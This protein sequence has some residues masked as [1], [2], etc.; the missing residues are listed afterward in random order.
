MD[1]RKLTLEVI[2]EMEFAND[3]EFFAM[4]EEEQKQLLKAEQKKEL[5][6]LE[7]LKNLP[8]WESKSHQIL[9]RNHR[10][11][12]RKLKHYEK[13]EDLFVEEEFEA[14]YRELFNFYDS[15]NWHKWR[16]CHKKYKTKF[17]DWLSYEL[18]KKLAWTKI[19]YDDIRGRVMVVVAGMI[20]EVDTVT[21]IPFV[22]RLKHKVFKN[23]YTNMI[24]DIKKPKRLLTYSQK[25]RSIQQLLEVGED[26]SDRKAHLY[27][28]AVLY[29]LDRDEGHR[30][31]LQAMDFSEQENAILTLWKT[32]PDISTRKLSAYIQI[33]QSTA[34][35]AVRKLKE[36]L[37]G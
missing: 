11:D 7:M 31:L 32:Q 15:D 13:I 37:A 27:Y 4:I 17:G 18:Y 21:G 35:R 10:N 2:I 19:E 36:K 14:L 28:E 1:Y 9:R 12:T 25:V 29:K 26:I 16:H 34:S 33:S 8:R 5:E 6:W 22:Y 20:E 3:M 23:L 30:Q 24:R